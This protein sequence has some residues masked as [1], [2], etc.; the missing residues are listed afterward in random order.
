MD[1]FRPSKKQYYLDIAK[2]V[3]KRA[4]CLKRSYGAVIVRNDSIVATG[5]NGPARGHPHCVEC[6]R[7]TKNPGEDYSECPA[8]HAE[9]NCIANAARSGH[10][11]IGAILFLYGDYPPCKRCK[12][13]LTNAGIIVIVTKT[14]VIDLRPEGPGE[15]TSEYTNGI[16]IETPEFKITYVPPY[17]YPIDPYPFPVAPIDPYPD[18][19]SYP[20]PIWVTTCDNSDNP[21]SITIVSKNTKRNKDDEDS[22]NTN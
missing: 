10:S 22:N 14:E 8:V 1:I 2:A 18:Y 11:T 12:R 3:S 5:Y 13:A 17:P 16:Y 9:E 19:P 20:Y 6:K 15:D 21:E 4:S 7:L